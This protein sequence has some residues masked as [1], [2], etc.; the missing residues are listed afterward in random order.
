MCEVQNYSTR[1]SLRLATI[2][3]KKYEEDILT[4]E[5]EYLCKL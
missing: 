3:N 1:R 2:G 5:D 4:D